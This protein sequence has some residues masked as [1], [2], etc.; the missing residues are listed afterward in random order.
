MNPAQFGPQEDF[1][2]YP[3]VFEQDC[4]KAE[5]AGCDILFAPSVSEMYFRNPSAHLLMLRR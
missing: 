1:E 5:E 2:K 4:A 3:R